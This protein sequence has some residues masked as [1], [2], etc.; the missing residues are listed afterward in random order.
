MTA[1]LRSDTCR[2]CGRT[3]DRASNIFSADQHPPRQGDMHVCINC[4]ALAVYTENGSRP[5]TDQERAL[6]LENPKVAS[7]I[8]H[9]HARGRF[10]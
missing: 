9:I 6:A 1:H 2:I 5:P 7:A 3:N 10:S 4:G 8:T